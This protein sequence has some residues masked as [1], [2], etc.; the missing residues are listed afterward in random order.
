MVIDDFDVHGT[1]TVC[2][3]LEANSPLIVDPDAPLTPSVAS[4]GFQTVAGARQIANINRGIELIQLA[5]GT[6]LKAGKR[7]D[8]AAQIERFCFLVPE[9]SDQRAANAEILITSSV[10]H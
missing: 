10:N 5:R 9:A 7:G 3:P 6:S 2:R 8:S 4:Q 1:G